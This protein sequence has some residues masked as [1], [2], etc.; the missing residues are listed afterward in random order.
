MAARKCLG[1][2][3]YPNTGCV[4]PLR[5]MPE[6]HAARILARLKSVS[7]ADVADLPHPWFYKSYLLFTWM[8]DLVRHPEILDAV[9][10]LIG[11]DIMVMSADIWMKQSG[12]KRHISFHQDAGYWHLDPLDI[13]TAWVALTPATITNGCMRFALG[14]HRLGN[15]EHHNTYAADNML[16]HGQTARID[17]RRW[18]HF[19]NELD[20]GEMSLHHA[21]LA[22]AS[23]PNTTEHQRGGICI[24][25][26]PG[27][28]AYTREP[29]VSAMVVRGSHDGNLEL[30][31][32]PSTDL[33]AE[34]VRQHTRLLAPHAATRYV[35]F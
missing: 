4:A 13:V 25:Y 35:T 19:D 21:L 8:D 34:A 22:H 33:C 2:E 7:A 17:V 10:L 30:E 3:D 5:V 1:F 14:T 32:P 15:V 29:A 16:S 20:P 31:D 11:P 18:P 23:G 26:L 9:E 6:A 24:R 12:E 28:I 27:R